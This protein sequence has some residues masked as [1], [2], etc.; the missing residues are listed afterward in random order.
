MSRPLRTAAVALLLVPLA[1]LAGCRDKPPVHLI[2]DMDDQPRAEAQQPSDFFYDGKV[3]RTPVEGTV[4]RE[5]P[6]ALDAYATG[7]GPDGT[8]VATIPAAA[9]RAVPDLATR[10]AERYRIYCA[11]CHGAAGDGKGVLLQRSGVE[12]ADLR[13][14]RLRDLG[15]GHLFDVV[16]NGLGLMSGYAVA[17]PVADRWAIVAHVRRLQAE[18][19]VPAEP[20]ATD[21]AATAPTASAEPVAPAA[22]EGGAR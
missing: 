6:V 9:R 1:G 4:A 15:D 2:P 7:R 22:P 18:S 12:S 19:P 21:Q 17:V 5:D 8:L 11:V 14:Q 16:S 3:M 13:Q 10:G 20:A